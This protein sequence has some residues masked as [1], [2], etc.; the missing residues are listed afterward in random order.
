[1]DEINSVRPEVVETGG[2][3]GPPPS[4][5]LGV[6]GLVTGIIGAVVALCCPILGFIL[7]IVALI[8]GFLAKGKNQKYATAGIILGFVSLGLGI[9]GI[10]LGQLG[11]KFL[12]EYN[13]EQFIQEMEQGL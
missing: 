13:W 7:G 5:A 2:P 1:M 4:N 9:L 10:I 11:L 3:S 8:C 6:T 12:E